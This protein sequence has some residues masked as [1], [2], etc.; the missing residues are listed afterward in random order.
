MLSSTGAAPLQPSLNNP[1]QIA[2]SGYAT[3]LYTVPAGR[4]FVGYIYGS[5]TGATYFITP[6]GGSPT[7][8]YAGAVLLTSQSTTPP[9]IVLVGGTVVAGSSVQILLN[10]I[11]S[12][13]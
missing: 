7:I 10:G 8:Q 6:V 9:Q 12:D 13:L 5:S 4:K 11:E 1:R 3:I 2:V